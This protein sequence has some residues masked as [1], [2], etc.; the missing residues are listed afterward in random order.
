MLR[1]CWRMVGNFI[2]L[3][4]IYRFLGNDKGCWEK[5]WVMPKEHLVI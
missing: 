5:N 1:K 4:F 2:Y 3:L